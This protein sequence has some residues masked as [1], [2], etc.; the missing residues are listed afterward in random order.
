MGCTYREAELIYLCYRSSIGYPECENLTASAYCY[1][2]YG[3]PCDVRDS[4]LS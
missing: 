3:V 4:K 2:A 1:A